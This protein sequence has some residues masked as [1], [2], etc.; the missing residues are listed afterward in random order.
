RAC[1][2]LQAHRKR[3]RETQAGQRFFAAPLTV[4]QG[5]V[6][7]ANQVTDGSATRVAIRPDACALARKCSTNPM[8]KI[9]RNRVADAFYVDFPAGELATGDIYRDLPTFGL[10]PAPRAPGIVITPACD[11]AQSKTPTA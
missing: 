6:S 8:R 10:L 2:C 11:L 9:A 5:R 1:P 7:E 3:L 4:N